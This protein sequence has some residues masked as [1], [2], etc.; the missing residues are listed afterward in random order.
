MPTIGHQKKK[1]APSTQPKS[2]M[3][4]AEKIKYLSQTE[5][6]KLLSVITSK[7]DYALFLLGYRHGLRS[8][9]IG[10]IRIDDID[11][12]LYRIRINRKKGSRAGVYPLQ[13]D[14]VKAIKTLLKER[15]SD[16]PYLFLSRRSE[17]ISPRMVDVLAKTYGAKAGLPEEKRHF[18]I[19]KHS[20]CTHL[21]DAG[22]EI[23]FVQDWVGHSSIKNTVLYAQ[24]SNTRRN[25]EAKKVFL[26]KHIV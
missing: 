12:A 25:E 7:R 23:R 17:P 13:P 26:N 4:T 10:M 6:K 8:S 19:L 15:N 14:E 3:W 1:P 5:M 2:K 9:E 11:L 20:I 21:L 18:H 24:L 16:S 22:A